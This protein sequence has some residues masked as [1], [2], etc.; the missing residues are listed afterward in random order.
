MNEEQV[1]RL[2]AEAED[3]A[4]DCMADGVGGIEVYVEP[5]IVAAAIDLALPYLM[6]LDDWK[7]AGRVGPPPQPAAM[8]PEGGH[9]G[10]IDVQPMRGDW[11]WVI[12]FDH[13]YDE[14]CRHCEPDGPDA[15]RWPYGPT[16][17]VRKG[18]A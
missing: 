12:P 1:L 3:L 8:T 10:P 5:R 13:D 6:E 16:E 2:V 7:Q 17:A 15:T 18:L 11:D 9:S 4:V 14:W